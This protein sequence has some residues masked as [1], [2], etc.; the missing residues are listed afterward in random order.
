M[1]QLY[2]NKVRFKNRD[3]YHFKMVDT[4]I[5]VSRDLVSLDELGISVLR[6]PLQGV[7]MVK[8]KN[9]LVLKPGAKNLFLCSFYSKGRIRT[10]FKGVEEDEIFT[11]SYIDDEEDTVDYQYLLLTNQEQIEVVWEA[12]DGDKGINIYYADGRV[13]TL[14]YIGEDDYP[15]L[16]QIT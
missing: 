7:E 12:D 13:E 2:L 16:C 15:V 14:P 5:F 10:E 6:L 8:A 1:V 9:V 3:F 4:V 11:S